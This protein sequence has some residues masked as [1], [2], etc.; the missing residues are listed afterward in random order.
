MEVD[1]FFG[2]IEL[3][4][5]DGM[6][7]VHYSWTKGYSGSR[8]YPPEPPQWE[9]E[10]IHDEDGEDVTGEL[11]EE[12]YD[13]EALLHQVDELIADDVSSGVDLEE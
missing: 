2:V 6:Y 13:D 11:I 1:Q 10:N 12:I 7:E 5:E 9:I 8:D 3:G 4:M